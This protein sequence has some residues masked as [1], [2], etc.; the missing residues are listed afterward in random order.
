MTSG[1]GPAAR[2]RAL[3]IEALEI[4][5]NDILAVDEAASELVGTVRGGSGPRFLVARTYR[6]TGHTSA[7]AAAYRPAEEVEER[8]SDDPIENCR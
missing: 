1:A 6:L 4:D 2:A 7:D 5:G 3:G 8:W